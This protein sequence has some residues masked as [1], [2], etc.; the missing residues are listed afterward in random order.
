M[1]YQGSCHCGAVAF[2]VEGE[3]DAAHLC[4]CSICRRKG[5]LMWFVARE[6][7]RLR[8]P[9][10]A[11]STYM[12]NK[13][14]VKHRFCPSCGIHPYGEAADPT[15]NPMAM[16]NLNCVDGLDLEAIPVTHFDGASH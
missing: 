11:A 13:H 2:E 14:A 15:V 8:T 12:F 7:L 16:V 4:N 9:E 1:L 6:Q 10:E 3:I 5:A